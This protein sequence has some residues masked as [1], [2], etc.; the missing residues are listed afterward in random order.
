MEKFC[1]EPKLISV[2]L[3]VRY[4]FGSGNGGHRE[5]ANHAGQSDFR[6]QN[7]NSLPCARL[8]T[9]VKALMGVCRTYAEPHLE[10][11]PKLAG[12]EGYAPSDLTTP[13]WGETGFHKKPSGFFRSTSKWCTENILTTPL[14]RYKAIIFESAGALGCSTTR[15]ARQRSAGRVR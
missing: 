5:A 12:H 3:R 13:F 2:G 4:I 15:G 11:D 9:I 7:C 14:S 10:E 6:S 8:W 1:R